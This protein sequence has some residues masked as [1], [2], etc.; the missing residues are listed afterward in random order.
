MNGLANTLGCKRWSKNGEMYVGYHQDQKWK[1]DVRPTSNI[2]WKVQLA[3][4][5]GQKCLK[6][7]RKQISHRAVV[8]KSVVV[9]CFRCGYLCN[10][11]FSQRKHFDA[12]EQRFEVICSQKCKIVTFWESWVPDHKGRDRP[13]GSGD[14][15]IFKWIQNWP[16]LSNWAKTYILENKSCLATPD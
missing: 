9:V 7:T 15:F 12:Q 16:K 3:G 5:D 1:T 8:R 2:S 4:P 13:G 6:K 11:W 10:Q 14:W